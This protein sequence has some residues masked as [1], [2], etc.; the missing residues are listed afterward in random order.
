[1]IA[2]LLV[3]ALAFYW[4][5]RET[6]WLRVR[7]LIGADKPQSIKLPSAAKPMLA[8]PMGNPN[9]YPMT[10]T[11]D[12]CVLRE[13]IDQLSKTELELTEEVCGYD[14]SDQA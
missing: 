4:M 6:D 8:L 3:I 1:M 13:L 2:T 5:L 12:T 11:I 10:L 9:N 7:L 14:Y